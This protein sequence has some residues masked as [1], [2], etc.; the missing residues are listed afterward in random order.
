[1]KNNPQKIYLFLSAMFLLLSCF[2]FYFLYRQINQK[3]SQSEQILMEWQKE[4]MRRD[5]IK[6]LE[7]SIKILANEKTELE[8]HF[9][10]SSD[11][12]PFLDTIEKLA[13]KAGTKME[14]L[15]VDASPNN[16]FLLVGL[17]S[18]GVFESL[19]KFLTLLE[20]SPYELEFYSLD[21]QTGETPDNSREWQAIFKIKLLSFVQ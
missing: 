7:H 4:A 20:N 9:A 21:I 6:S 17:K 11:V 12:V 5:E 14:V 15:S 13:R 2:I 1:M 18:T 8:T 19:Y 3:N 16:D 10:K